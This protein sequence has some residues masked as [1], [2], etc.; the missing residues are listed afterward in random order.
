MA[1]VL[2]AGHSGSGKK[3]VADELINKYGYGCVTT[4]SDRPKVGLDE[5]SPKS[6]FI[7][8]AVFK[9]M[10]EKGMFME[11]STHRGHNYG[12]TRTKLLTSLEEH[13]N[14]VVIMTP[15]GVAKL[16]KYLIANNMPHV[17]VFIEADAKEC[18]NNLT[19]AY[20]KNSLSRDEYIDRITALA[21]SESKW[22][23]DAKKT[24]TFDIIME[25]NYDH[26]DTALI[27]NEHVSRM[28]QA[29]ITPID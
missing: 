24:N 13:T 22:Y 10:A 19:A 26:E 28:N 3:L 5:L 1:L 6:C 29:K 20:D 11:N 9:S 21:T 25:M 12:L 17:A 14:A 15:E 8:P 23:D 27:L 18:V 7:S 2:L 16:R 4:V